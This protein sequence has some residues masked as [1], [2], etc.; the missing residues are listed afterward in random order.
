[1]AIQSQ[2]GSWL[3]DI[4]LIL[5]SKTYQHDIPRI[6]LTNELHLQ[7]MHYQLGI[8]FASTELSL[9][10]RRIQHCTAYIASSHPL[11]QLEMLFPVNI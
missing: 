11:H 7:E 8:L 1:L 2:V 5:L 6:G 4:E 3:G 10:L 9:P